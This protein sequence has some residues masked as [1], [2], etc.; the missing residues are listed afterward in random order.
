[1]T[2]SRVIFLAAFSTS[3]CFTMQ[4]AALAA[5][6]DPATWVS[7]LNDDD[8]DTRMMAREKLAAMGEAAR[9]ALTTAVKNNADPE[10]KTA[11]RQILG[12]MTK[13]SLT[14][15]TVNR[16]G[17]TIGEIQG[18][19]TVYRGDMRFGNQGGEKAIP[20]VTNTQGTATLPDLEPGRGQVNVAWK[21]WI[22][23]NFGM[24]NWSASLNL[25]A[26][27]NPMLVTLTKP[28]SVSGVIQDA[29]G[30][31]LKD[32]ELVLFQNM[33]FEADADVLA[34]QLSTADQ[35]QR[36]KLSGN[37]DAD[38]TVKVEG[39]NEGIYQCVARAQNFQ[40]A[41][42]GSVR[43]REGD[44]TTVAPVKLKPLHKG[45]LSVVLQK[46]DGT[47][48]KKTKVSTQLEPVFEGAEAARKLARYRSMRAVMEMRQHQLP[49]TET[50]EQGKLTI[51]DVEAGTYQ[52]LVTPVNDSSQNVGK[53]AVDAGA[54]TEL[55]AFKFKE[56]YSLKGRITGL[57]PRYSRAASL[58]AVR[59]DLIDLQSFD[60]RTT[61]RYRRGSQVQTQQ[62]GTYELKN[63]APGTYAICFFTGSGKTVLLCNVEVAAD[64]E[65]VAPD[66]II[67][68]AAE[69]QQATVELKGTVTLPNGSPAANV[70]VYYSSTATSNASQTDAKGNFRMSLWS[71]FP[72]SV[73]VKAPGHRT[74]NL[75]VKNEE[76]AKAGLQIRLEKQAFGTL[77]ARVVDEK[78]EALIGASVGPRRNARSEGQVRMSSNGGMMVPGV[79]AAVSTD[80]KGEARLQGLGAGDRTFNVELPGYYVPS[81]VKGQIVADQEQTLTVT[82]KA[83]ISINGKLEL[84]EGANPANMLVTANNQEYHRVK[85]NGEFS[86]TGLK[87]GK[88][89]LRVDAPGYV[90]AA[91]KTE[92]ILVDGVQPAPV[93]VWLIKPAGVALN[94]GAE[95]VGA[96]ASLIQYENVEENKFDTSGSATVD[97]SGRIE[98]WGV[99]PGKY[100]VMLNTRTDYFLAGQR[101]QHV[102]RAPYIA[103]PIEAVTTNS[104]TDLAKMKAID[105]P[106][107]T[108][109]ASVSGRIAPDKLPGNQFGYSTYGNLKLRL[110]GPS[111][112]AETS[113]NYPSEF[114]N[115]EYQR[116]VVLNAPEGVV[117]ANE[118]G[119]FVMSNLV[120]GDYRIEATLNMYIYNNMTGA[121]ETKD[122]EKEKPVVVAKFALKDG[123]KRDLGALKYEIGT[124]EGFANS[125][126]DAEPEDEAPGFQP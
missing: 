48:L 88:Y 71:T 79:Y 126:Q 17:K 120:A 125:G 14:L 26:G 93:T 31:A 27:D 56:G 67:P 1:M 29:D 50:D 103:G 2:L 42:V 111:T 49:T 98:F 15:L 107:K 61:Y 102:M 6:D 122:N 54:T 32:G 30:K 123:E 44:I 109:T 53:V 70:S 91:Q 20:I 3:L 58:L 41:L 82:M 115:N 24:G 92:L 87:P 118:A 12:T 47:P 38:G 59:Q 74:A 121:Y 51:E 11:A 89:F 55:E 110:V 63:L 36:M 18:D 35:W 25:R 97:G 45:K 78:G 34:L 46:P 116:I 84:P 100:H 69:Q 75:T 64:K 117:P 5:E 9:A 101:S 33:F 37:S 94:V 65:N 96:T 124:L 119:A 83:G 77:K 13:S 22:V 72:I 4:H 10:I 66:A 90:T 39:V 28:G 16:D 113:F 21:G 81:P 104:I 85:P 114:V 105:V 43:V 73:S 19:A 112:G 60:M 80:E 40:P 99:R 7:K 23:P 52:L 76:E 62:D 95:H 68:Q 106:V 8:Y 57:D 86:I 108:G